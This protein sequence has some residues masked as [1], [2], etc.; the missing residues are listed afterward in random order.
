MKEINCLVS[1]IIRVL[2][3]MYS[4]DESEGKVSNY[5]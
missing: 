5:N 2:S 3:S 4:Q 1:D